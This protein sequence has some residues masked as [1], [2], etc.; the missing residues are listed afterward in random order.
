MQAKNGEKYLVYNGYTYKLNKKT[1]KTWYLI[2]SSGCG[3]TMT[4]TPNYENIKKNSDRFTFAPSVNE[5]QKRKHP[6]NFRKM[7]K[8]VEKDPTKTLKNVYE[9]ICAKNASMI[10]PTFSSVKS[11]LY[12][13]RAKKLPKIP[14]NPRRVTIPRKWRQTITKKIVLKHDKNIVVA[15]FATERKTKTLSECSAILCDGF[16][17]SCPRPFC[18]LF[19]IHGLKISRK[20]PLIWAFADGKTTAHYRKIFQVVKSKIGENW[21]PAQLISD[22]ER[23]IIAAVEMEFPHSSH[24]WCYFHFTQAIYRQIQKLGLS[25]PY[26]EDERLR[27]FT[28]YLMATPFLPPVKFAT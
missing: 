11:T 22:F 2:C 25:V 12:R 18:Q 7:K 20:I 8:V 24:K 6:Q 23:A 19:S 21:G 14:K 10:P 26:K 27:L 16:F 13:I 17:K 9:D 28:R 3:A 4:M 15:V 1:P 5:C